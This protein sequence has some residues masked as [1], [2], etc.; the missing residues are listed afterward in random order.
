MEKT[1]ATVKAE[2]DVAN[3][4]AEK[5]AAKKKECEDD[6]AV[7]VPVLNS[8]IKALNTLSPKDISQVKAMSNPPQG[9]R[10]TMAAV[11]VM[12]DIKPDRVPDPNGGVKKVEDFWGP[13]K[14]LLNDLKFLDRLINYDKDNIPPKIM[15]KIRKQYI[16]DEE[17]QP[18]K[19]AKA[20]SAAEGMCKWVRALERY[21]IVAKEVAPKK[22]ALAE[23][24][25]QLDVCIFSDACFCFV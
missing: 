15:E 9:V 4:E 2:A 7:A 6:L 25:A 11:C 1:R 23:A 17:F 12:L 22:E 21:D 8:A 20:S 24:Q 16:D 13:A 5:V 3:A 18:E 10:V 14:K 19:V